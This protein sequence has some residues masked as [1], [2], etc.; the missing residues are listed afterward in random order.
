MSDDLN[1]KI[2]KAKCQTCSAVKKATVRYLRLCPNCDKAVLT[3]AA[4]S[5]GKPP[6]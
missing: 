5:L 4:T 1:V 3:L 2:K 6:E